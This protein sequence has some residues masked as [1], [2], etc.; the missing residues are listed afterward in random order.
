[1]K[2]GSFVTMKRCLTFS[3]IIGVFCISAGFASIPNTEVQEI[4]AADNTSPLYKEFRYGASLVWEIRS[5]VPAIEKI[6]GLTL[7]TPMVFYTPPKLDETKNNKSER[8]LL[9]LTRSFYESKNWIALKRSVELFEKKYSKS[10]FLAV[11]NYFK[12]CALLGQGPGKKTVAGALTLLDNNAEETTDY[13]IKRGSWLFVS[14]YSLETKDWSRALD[15]AKKLYL[16]AIN[17]NDKESLSSSAEII[18]HALA[19]AAMPEKILEVLRDDS[20]R[21]AVSPI[22]EY[23]YKL[24]AFLASG[25][26]ASAT[27]YYQQAIKKDIRFSSSDLFNA[28]EAFFRM[29]KF[30]EARELFSKSLNASGASSLSDRALLRV[31]VID[32]LTSAPCEGILETYKRVMVSGSSENKIEAR[33]RYAGI[34]LGRKVSPSA[35]DMADLGL[36]DRTAEENGI[37]DTNLK[38]LLWITRLHILINTARFEEAYAYL[39]AI[40]VGEFSDIEK[41]LIA[42]DEM[43]TVTGLMLAMEEKGEW[44]RI[45]DLW[46]AHSGQYKETVARDPSIVFAAAKAALYEG[47]TVIYK[48][49]T[50]TLQS[51]QVS[52]SGVWAE[53]GLRDGQDY[54]FEIKTIEAV[55]ANNIK[56]AEKIIAKWKATGPVGGK[57]SFYEGM[58][59]WT[60]KDYP[61]AVTAFEKVILSDL[62]SLLIAKTDWPG[63]LKAFGESLFYSASAEQFQ[64]AATALLED[65]YFAALKDPLLARSRERLFYLT[66]ESQSGTTETTVSGAFEESAGKFLLEYPLS[67]FTFRV[68]YLLGTN[69]L[70]SEKIEVGRKILLSLTND[71]AA[72]TETRKNAAMELSFGR[73]GE[74]EM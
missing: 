35:P 67:P 17:N 52:T 9:N 36:L 49:L 60:K 41:K 24:F 16:A 3:A 34:S 48:K 19:N 1:M 47:E 65:T 51:L 63:F 27:D 6:D 58:I 40:H 33:I 37:I 8:A 29:K 7:Q 32:E 66:I 18:L 11:N 12:A 57:I 42:E 23:S 64:K 14:R 59:F 45:L 20:F 44:R 21:Q 69:L 15:N 68:R 28:G 70:K 54:L 50:E 71:S 13:E 31:A 25:Q 53:S 39:K 38:K 72:P 56:D 22:T 10:E 4:I 2:Q 26:N 62:S 5:E 43:F 74:T 46:S 73:T 61:A 30:K 55:K